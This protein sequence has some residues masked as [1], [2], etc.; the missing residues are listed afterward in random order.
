[1]MLD[2]H[3]ESLIATG[4]SLGVLHVL[5]GPDHLSAL[6][7]LSVGSSWRAFS[8]GL[9]WG[10]G[11]STGLIV[12][13]VIF[14]LMKGDLD[15]KLLGRYCDTL[16]GGFMIVLGAYG[17]LSAIRVNRDKAKKSD[18]DL[19]ESRPL[20]SIAPPNLHSAL[21]AVSSSITGSNKVNETGVMY[22]AQSVRVT[23]ASLRD[24]NTSAHTHA[25]SSTSSVNG[26][27]ASNSTASSSSAHARDYP[28]IHSELDDSAH[29]NNGLHINTIES[30]LSPD[31]RPPSSRT[32]HHYYTD[33][34]VDLNKSP[35][36]AYHNNSGQMLDHHDIDFEGLERDCWILSWVDMR[37]PTV[38]RIVSFSIGLLHGV[39]GPGMYIRVDVVTFT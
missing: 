25:H 11:H 8:L 5:A 27:S 24:R 6:A 22:P 13:A 36:H 33:G 19:N 7:A 9:R 18:D 17:V 31:S 28:G 32:P 23:D 35:S 3:T 34:D 38:Q 29:G 39:A 37:D 21:G 1:M 14:I 20:L 16:V 4:L 15:L 2:T 10:L 12:V 30:G 26:S